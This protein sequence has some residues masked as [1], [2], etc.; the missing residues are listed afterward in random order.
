MVSK[1]AMWILDLLQMQ[2]VSLRT[3]MDNKRIRRDRFD[4]FTYQDWAITE[5]LLAIGDYSGFVDACLIK[6]ILRMQ[7]EDYNK[8][9]NSN[10]DM[11]IKYK[12]AAEMIEYLLIL[13]EVY[14]G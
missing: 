8:Y 1:D 2:I 6:E 11:H 9:Y 13:T 7:L 5:T 3:E 12:Y 14:E 10:R 4:K